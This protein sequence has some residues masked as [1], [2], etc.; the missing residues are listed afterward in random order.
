MIVCILNSPEF[1]KLKFTLV[2]IYPNQHSKSGFLLAQMHSGQTLRD[3]NLE[4][5]QNQFGH[6]GGGLSIPKDPGLS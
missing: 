6:T 4:G 3:P 5:P 2:W 1:T